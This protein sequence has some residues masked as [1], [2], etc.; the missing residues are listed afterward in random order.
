MSI[1][2]KTLILISF[3]VLLST[4][5]LYFFLYKSTTTT[6]KV[7]ENKLAKENVERLIEALNAQA[8][9]L[10][11]KTGDWANWDD[12]YNFIQSKNDAF[13]EINY[14]EPTFEQLEVNV[15]LFIDNNRNIYFSKE[16][17]LQEQIFVNLNTNWDKILTQETILQKEID[18]STQGII[19]LDGKPMLIAA[20]PILT[21]AGEGPIAGTL[22]M[23]RYLDQEMILSLSKT[24]KK[25]LTL[26]NSDETNLRLDDANNIL[27]KTVDKNNLKGYALINDVFGNPSI[28]LE[29]KLTR[30]VYNYGLNGLKSFLVSFI[31]FGCIF[32]LIIGWLLEYHLISKVTK[33]SKQV[34]EIGPRNDPSMRVNK[35]GSDEI[36][37]LALNINSTLDALE[38]LNEKVSY[39][40]S[41]RKSILETMGEGVVVTNSE[42]KIVYVNPTFISLFGYESKEII[43]KEFDKIFPAYNLQEKQLPEDFLED[44][45]SKIAKGSQVK[46]ILQGKK[47]KRAVIINTSP[48]LVSGNKRGVVRV[49]HD[50]ATELE[51]IKQKDDFFSIASHEL[52]TPLTIISGDLDNI[53]QGYGE[54]ELSKADNDLM[55]D[56]VIASDR[57]IDMINDFLNVSR[58]DEG[59]LVLDIKPVSICQLTQ[60]IIKEMEKL[61]AAKNIKLNF[62]CDKKHPNVIA[63]E[64]KLRQIIVNLLGNSLKYTNSGSVI[65]KHYTSSNMLISEI[66]DTGIGI[67]PDKQKLL[68]QRF[69]QLVTKTLNRQPGGTGLGLYISRELTKLMGG[70]MWL[71]KSTPDKGSTFAFSLPLE[72]KLNKN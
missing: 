34:A 13:V 59:R 38:K 69:Q 26:I 8:S 21:S 68:F 20:K 42:K 36:G 28:I 46:V 43:D 49:F 65:I 53:L 35:Y 32:T 14:Q 44:E 56:T 67:S 48:I 12:S 19:M 40:S 16:Y 4:I 58:L 52:R 25:P 39:E 63:D 54:S 55:K 7:L 37:N 29:E 24:V 70:D 3:T 23:G 15:I 50:Y 60:D 18:K 10:S 71:V 17:N 51:L 33:L 47:V 72:N 64:N 57:L 9:S 1:R 11:S 6:Y 41:Q 31:I 5:S 22:I 2:V 30:D 27:I 62:S 45:K 61:F 66:S